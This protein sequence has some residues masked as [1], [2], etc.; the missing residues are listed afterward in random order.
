[1]CSLF[2]FFWRVHYEDKLQRVSG[3]CRRSGSD[4]GGDTRERV[5][6][7]R[8]TRQ[9]SQASDTGVPGRMA[10]VC[11]DTEVCFTNHLLLLLDS[12]LLLCCLWPSLSSPLVLCHLHRLWQ[13][14]SRPLSRG[15]HW[16]NI[17]S[18]I[19]RGGFTE[20]L[21]SLKLQCLWLAGTPSKNV[22]LIF[23]FTIL[24][25]FS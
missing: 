15:L 24:Y 7:R 6:E 4:N 2:K 20:K 14:L 5:A 3:I 23:V 19:N 25:P 16:D 18:A 21:I 9:W 17:S 10:R 12:L 22:H 11:N 8:G 1:M 13:T